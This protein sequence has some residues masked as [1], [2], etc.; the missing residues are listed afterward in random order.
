MCRVGENRNLKICQFLALKNSRNRIGLHRP[1]GGWV[2]ELLVQKIKLG[3]AQGQALASR[4]TVCWNRKILV[5][6]VLEQGIL[7]HDLVGFSN[8]DVRAIPVRIVNMVPKVVRERKAFGCG[9]RA[10][11]CHNRIG[12]RQHDDVVSEP[13]VAAGQEAAGVDGFLQNPDGPFVGAVNRVVGHI[14]LDRS[15]KCDRGLRP[16][17]DI[18]KHLYPCGLKMGRVGP[19][20]LESRTAADVQSPLAAVFEKITLN[21]DVFAAALAL[22]GVGAHVFKLVCDDF[23]KMATHHV[24]PAA[25]CGAILKQTIPNLKIIQ[26]GQFQQVVVAARRYIA[27]GALFKN[28]VVGGGVVRATIVRVQA[29][30]RLVLENE[31]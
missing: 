3:V 14:H 20:K 24:N 21:P 9:V 23:P 15:H 28:D 10:N 12:V 27:E 2:G 25:S 8:R 29:I 31:P 19:E 18:G 7:V 16:D 11:V 5:Q 6:R 30:A 1:D 17:D 26:P 4:R 22:N 13:V